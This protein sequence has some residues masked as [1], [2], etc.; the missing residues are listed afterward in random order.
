MKPKRA[1]AHK[2]TAK[3]VVSG[4]AADYVTALVRGL[5]VL[6]CF[7]AGRRRMTLSQVAA[8]TKLSRGTS[9]RL[10]LTLQ[11]AGYVHGD[12]KSFWL[13]PKVLQ[14]AKAFLTSNGLAEVARPFIRWVTEETGEFLL[15]RGAG[16][17][18]YCLYRACRNTA[19]LLFRLR[20][21]NTPTSALRI[22]GSGLT[23]GARTGSTRSLAKGLS[24]RCTYLQNHY[25]SR[26]P[27]P[28]AKG[29]GGAE[30]CD[31]RRRA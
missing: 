1:I 2:Q 15:C 24:A 8:L 30:V 28:Q 19:H 14:L 9:R 29:G 18:R 25:R 16:R 7:E 21:W 13:T 3:S 17:P 27:T 11:A 4:K 12:G 26:A 5:D 31:V 10:L 23:G 22:V 6:T 20:T